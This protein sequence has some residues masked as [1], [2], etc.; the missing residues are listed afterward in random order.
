[1]VCPNC[2]KHPDDE[3][4]KVEDYTFNNNKTKE[5]CMFCDALFYT[6]KI[7]GTDDYDVWVK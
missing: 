3:G 7:R 6:Q 2:G 5:Q 4:L 1:M